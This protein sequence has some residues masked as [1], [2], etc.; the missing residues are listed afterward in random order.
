[1]PWLQTYWKEAQGRTRQ[2]AT[3]MKRTKTRRTEAFLMLKTIT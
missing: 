1:M 2:T 3:L